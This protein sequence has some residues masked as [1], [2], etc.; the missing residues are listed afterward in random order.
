MGINI[1]DFKL[2]IS[3]ITNPRIKS[4]LLSNLADAASTIPELFAKVFPQ[5][6]T[7]VALETESLIAPPLAL[8]FSYAP[9]TLCDEL[10]DEL[11]ACE[12]SEF[13]ALLSDGADTALFFTLMKYAPQTT[14]AKIVA[15]LNSLNEDQITQL[16]FTNKLGQTNF[17][18]FNNF[19][20]G[21]DDN[22]A[23]SLVDALGK[24]SPAKFTRLVRTTSFSA[25]AGVVEFFEKTH[26]DRIALA[27][28]NVLDCLEWKDLDT[29][30]NGSSSLLLGFLPKHNLLHT[31]FCFQSPTVI[32]SLLRLL[33][34]TDIKTIKALFS[35]EDS[36]NN[37]TP[38][39]YAFARN[40]NPE[41]PI[42]VGQT[43]V[44]NEGLRPLFTEVSTYK[45][46][47]P[48]HTAAARGYETIV[49][50]YLEQEDAQVDHQTS[51]SESMLQLAKAA[52]QSAIQTLF[53]ALPMLRLIQKPDTSYSEAN[54]AKYLQQNPTV[55]ACRWTGGKTLLHLAAAR[56]LDKLVKLFLQ[57]GASIKSRDNKSSTAIDEALRYHQQS[58][59]KE[60]LATKNDA[61]IETL[62][63]ILTNTTSPVTNYEV[64]QRVLKQQAGISLASYCRQ[65]KDSYIYLLKEAARHLASTDD[66]RL[67][68]AVKTYILLGL[69][70]LSASTNQI[71]HKAIQL[72]LVVLLFSMPTRK[73]LDLLTSLKLSAAERL[74]LGFVLS[75]GLVQPLIYKSFTALAHN[76]HFQFLLNL[77]PEDPSLLE[78]IAGIHFY[79][80]NL[81]QLP[82]E[83]L[84]QMA[85]F[86]STES[87]LLY[88]KQ[89]ISPILLVLTLEKLEANLPRDNENI[90]SLLVQLE[91]ELKLFNQDNSVDLSQL[92]NLVSQPELKA[93]IRNMLQQFALD[94][95]IQQHI[96]HI[97]RTFSQSLRTNSLLAELF[98]DFASSPAALEQPNQQSLERILSISSPAGVK[99]IIDKQRARIREQPL[100][101]EPGEQPLGAWIQS[102]K[103]RTERLTLGPLITQ[104][105]QLYDQAFDLADSLNKE[106]ERKLY[107]A[108]ETYGLKLN[109]LASILFKIHLN[110]LDQANPEKLH[111]LLSQL[112]PALTTL[113]EQMASSTIS[114]NLPSLI[115]TERFAS[116]SAEIKTVCLKIDESRE[117]QASVLPSTMQE[118]EL[119]ASLQQHLAQGL[120]QNPQR[121][122][123][124]H[125]LFDCCLDSQAYPNNKDL[126]EQFYQL[127]QSA[128]PEEC[129]ELDQK[130]KNILHLKNQ[131]SL[132]LTGLQVT[133]LIPPTS[134][135]SILTELY[136]ADIEVLA[137]LIEFA[138]LL[139]LDDFKDLVSYVQTAKAQNVPLKLLITQSA[140]KGSDLTT[141]IE[142]NLDIIDYSAMQAISCKLLREGLY[143]PE[144][145]L[146]SR[147]AAFNEL[148]DHSF[149]TAHP[150]AINQLIAS[151]SPILQVKQES[152]ESRT[153]IQLISNLFRNSR[154]NVVND[155]ICQMAPE[156][157]DQLISHCLSGLNSQDEAYD[158]ASRHLLT[159]LC[160]SYS[161]ANSKSLELIK[162][163]LSQPDLSLLGDR[164]LVT[165]AESILAKKDSSL[166]SST[167]NGVWIQRLLTSVNFVASSNPQVIYA[168]CERYR[169]ISLTLKQ[170]EFEQ[171][172]SWIQNKMAFPN[173]HQESMTRLEK[174]RSMSA[175]RKNH[176]LEKREK[177]LAFRAEDSIRALLNQLEDACIEQKSSE[178]EIADKALGVLYGYYNDNLTSLR[179]DLLFKVAD[180][181]VSAASSGQQK[182]Q[183]K[184]GNTLVEWLKNYLPHQNFVQTE[185][186]RKQSS[187]IYNAERGK[188][189]FI[190]EANYAMTFVND[191]PRP[192][193]GLPGIE[194]GMSFYD[195]EQRLIGTLTASG[196]V[197]YESLFQA[198]TSALLL[199]K[200]PAE[201]LEQSTA[202]MDL[203][204]NDIFTENT[205]AKVYANSESDKQEWLSRE[206]NLRLAASTKV[207]HQDNLA[208]IVRY[209]PADKAFPLL[210]DI[211]LSTNAEQLFEV[212]LEND[213]KRRELFS[214]TQQSA[215]AAF[216]DKQD[217]SAIFANFLNNHKDKPWFTEGLQLFANYA[218]SSGKPELLSNA[219]SLL[220][221]R[222]YTHKNLTKEQFDT[223]LTTLLGS[224]ANASLIWRYFLK[225]SSLE[226]IQQVAPELAEQF[227]SFFHKQHCLPT[228][229]ALNKQKNWSQS[230]YQY[231]LLLLI[232]EKQREFLF[233]K[234]ELRYS[235]KM[236]WSG[237][238]LK[239]ISVFIKRHFSQRANPDKDLAIGKELLGELIFR[240][241]NHGRTELFYNNGQFDPSIAVQKLERS[242]L[243]ALAARDYL[244][245]EFRN[246]MSEV[247]S[248]IISWFNNEHAENLKVREILRDNHALIDWK[249]LSNQTWNLS[250]SWTKMP[251]ISAYLINY[252]GPNAPLLK[253][254]TDYLSNKRIHS[255]AEYLH[256][257]SLVMAKLPQRDFSVCIFNKLEELVTQKS[258]YLDRKLLADMAAFYTQRY[259]GRSLERPQAEMELLK[260]F[261]KQKK[262]ELVEQCCNL[263]ESEM[264]T[265]F[266]GQIG[267][268]AKVEAR[269]NKH[270]SSWY[271]PIYQFFIRLWNYGLW[272]SSESDKIVPYCDEDS[273]YSS[274]S[275]TPATIET[276]N[277]SGK[278]IDDQ[279]KLAKNTRAL[280][281]RYQ[282]FLEKHPKESD[283]PPV[284][285][286]SLSIADM[287][288][289]F[290]PV[291]PTGRIEALIN[292]QSLTVAS[293]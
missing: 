187:L 290:T 169:F 38:I 147:A 46:Q 136:N 158:K 170:A 96:Q 73:R 266:L 104:L 146:S 55:L 173:H 57:H 256:N 128:K 129:E 111:S 235:D 48:M 99:T 152:P 159:H 198:N 263:L 274:P 121:K 2:E 209:Q 163:R 262:Y 241:A 223:L 199:A 286:L 60:L 179:S 202:A 49:T 117:P 196:E 193:L 157:L 244:P 71:E 232:L 78:N 183:P 206:I 167:M 66:Q 171:L 79:N 100:H 233:H 6:R 8:A 240:C 282:R 144:S 177:L 293:S 34:K 80:S 242:I 36:K 56:G 175:Q 226:S 92:F 230:S 122:Q 86:S 102:L 64:L 70:R 148:I 211:N 276:P 131:T 126:S 205:L 19:L 185:L 28:L 197:R 63:N 68:N 141:W 90:E 27:L 224:E 39:E 186:S 225:S 37:F 261:A 140:A 72:Q 31:I 252:T 160:Q 228:I 151:Y 69:Q 52:N 245:A 120:L 112:Q 200:V 65:Q 182:N 227:A 237:A 155:C 21:N 67:E 107:R 35:K 41:I 142:H 156:I 23:I 3:K 222:V 189:G 178:P 215:V 125:Q 164:T 77:S 291:I 234:E 268:H 51:S 124:I 5:D 32:Q 114:K 271:Y 162:T 217:A 145:D 257:I 89:R 280:K 284:E 22:I 76:S 95:P 81:S 50:Y 210:A 24:I 192:L 47:S 83:T 277:M 132:L 208:A 93:R 11:I 133:A 236:A 181:I 212:I 135:S 184:A 254:I 137:A 251:L 195:N 243:N 12:D 278:V 85:E 220:D 285:K 190:N 9:T 87:L 176:L 292:P 13:T 149:A 165:I 29:V 153:A 229:E 75:Y 143:Q 115:S 18:N 289:L 94:S 109:D 264:S 267:K 191:V 180:F 288:S 108:F 287:P 43:L 260:H 259:Q 172:N 16:I 84:Q 130:I 281:T 248:S 166:S 54:V 231:R 113:R 25:H 207:L 279:L 88:C 174:A 214:E 74:Q 103:N 239:E 59:L 10:A 270:V 269:L 134:L 30:I 258:S 110:E 213:S 216:L 221:E 40:D 275:T 118:P 249:E 246:K 188:I 105:D 42:I 97:C 154:I 106:E 253:L 4:F 91:N 194:P 219:L 204:I 17:A 53:A 127:V 116:L 26:S 161:E 44:E 123:F 15:R 45:S 238:E 218:Q 247:F 255:K 150:H 283:L 265:S 119:L 168:L 139:G 82:I 62:A 273:E 14:R 203:L 250:D 61:T 98:I 33:R 1:E 138:A 101:L 20:E 58:C 7:Q 201:Q 272:G